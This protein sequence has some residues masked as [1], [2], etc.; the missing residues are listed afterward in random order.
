MA[1]EVHVL[2]MYED[3]ILF[4]I[5]NVLVMILLAVIVLFSISLCWKTKKVLP[6][7]TPLCRR[8]ISIHTVYP[9]SPHSIRFP[10]ILQEIEPDSPSVFGSEPPSY[11]VYQPS[12]QHVK[13]SPVILNP[14]QLT[15]A[16][17]FTCYAPQIN[18]G[19]AKDMVGV[20]VVRM[21]PSPPK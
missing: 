10:Q 7:P 15:S 2:S 18:Q 12:P 20:H 1:S 17:S 6:P 11:D 16:P 21:P 4:Y 13:T 9:P 8:Q 19:R 14:L 3:D 5:I